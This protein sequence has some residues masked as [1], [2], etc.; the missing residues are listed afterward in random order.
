MNSIIQNINTLQDNNKKR[1]HSTIKVE[2]SYNISE[3]LSRPSINNEMCINIH[4]QNDKNKLYNINI[5]QTESDINII[6]NCGT[7]YGIS[8]RHDCKHISTVISHMVSNYLKTN[9][10]KTKVNKLSNIFDN[11]NIK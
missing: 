10:K 8:E 4:S 7:I 2:Q 11:L 3:L 5:I 1:K 6:C 9:D